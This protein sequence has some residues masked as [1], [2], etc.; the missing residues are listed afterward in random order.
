MRKKYYIAYGSNLSV[1]QMKYRTPDARI[2]GTAVLEGWQLIFKR[3]ATI[4]PR[5]GY[6]TPVLIWEI[7][8]QDERNLD[9]Y[10]GYPFYYRKEQMQVE[11]S[12]LDGGKTQTVEA[13]VYL[14]V[15]EHKYHEP[16]ADYYR[17]LL[18]GYQD[19]GFSVPILERALADSIGKRQAAAWL[20]RS[21]LQEG[22]KDNECVPQ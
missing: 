15:E 3:H 7:S 12:P 13:M 18:N 1:N 20:K 14:M 6:Q 21:C 17:V 9:L 5:E 4:R 22:E 19:L 11:V 2:I 10:E 8:E 16:S